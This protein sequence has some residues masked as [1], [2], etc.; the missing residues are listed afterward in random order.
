MCS[1]FD[2]GDYIC[3]KLEVYSNHNGE[4][5]SLLEKPDD[6]KEDIIHISGERSICAVKYSKELGCQNP[7]SLSFDQIPPKQIKNIKTV[8]TNL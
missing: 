8:E 1:L 5:M 3:W 2:N 4:N 6:F 7:N